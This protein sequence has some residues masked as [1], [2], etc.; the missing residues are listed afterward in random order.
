MLLWHSVHGMY[1]PMHGHLDT[2]HTGCRIGR[3]THSSSLLNIYYQCS[4]LVN[5]LCCV[6]KG[7]T[8]LGLGRW[9][10]G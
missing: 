6:W 5:A 10:L 1:M 7:C 2:H 9:Q 3:E 8:T 4:Y